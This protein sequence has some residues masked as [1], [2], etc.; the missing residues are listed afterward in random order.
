MSP[1]GRAIAARVG[2]VALEVEVLQRHLHAALAVGDR[3][4]HLLDERRLAAAQPSMT[5]ELPQRAGAVE[6]VGGDQRGQVEELAHRSRLGQRDAAD[7]EVDVEVGVVDPR[8]GERLT[9]AGWTRQ[10]SRGTAALARSMRRADGRSRA[11]S[12]IETVANVDVR[13][14]SFSRRHI[15]PSASLIRRSVARASSDGHGADPAP[16]GR[17]GLPVSA[18]STCA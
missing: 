14:G 2:C 9:G 11:W 17:R 4:V 15:R 16:A 12:R 7:V 18:G 8:R 13:Y 6:R 5:R 3:V 10:R 1:V